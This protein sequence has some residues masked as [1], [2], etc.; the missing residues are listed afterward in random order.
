MPERTETPESPII[1]ATGAK[2][3]LWDANVSI[4]Q[5][6]G[7]GPAATRKKKEQQQQQK[8]RK[9]A[10][11]RA[12]HFTP[13]CQLHFCGWSPMDAMDRAFEHLMQQ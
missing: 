5:K 8:I 4:K 11:S 9:R 1:M 6:S 12:K 13:K 2:T 3:H 10:T 7:G